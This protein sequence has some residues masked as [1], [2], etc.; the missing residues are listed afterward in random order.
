[1]WS[2]KVDYQPLIWKGKGKWEIVLEG[3]QA[4]MSFGGQLDI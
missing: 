4:D 2:I 1:M 3:Y